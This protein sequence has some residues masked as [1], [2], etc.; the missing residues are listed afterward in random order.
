MAAGH[1]GLPIR[2]TFALRS[3]KESH[4]MSKAAGGASSEMG[5]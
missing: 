2:F 4:L 3:R 5:R 1:W